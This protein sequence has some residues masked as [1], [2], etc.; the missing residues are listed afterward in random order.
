VWRHPSNQVKLG[1]SVF[2]AGASWNPVSALTDGR[3]AYDVH[4]AS[5]ASGARPL[6]GPEAFS[7]C[8]RKSS[9]GG[10][11]VMCL[12]VTMF[13]KV[14]VLV[15]LAQ[16]N[17]FR[18]RLGS[19]L[20]QSGRFPTILLWQH[21]TQPGFEFSIQRPAIA[22][23]ME[24]LPCLFRHEQLHEAVQKP[25][26]GRHVQKELL[27]QQLWVILRKDLDRFG[28]GG[29]DLWALTEEADGFVVVDLEYFVGVEAI[30]GR[31]RDGSRRDIKRLKSKFHQGDAPRDEFGE[32]AE[33]VLN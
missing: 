22:H 14:L 31:D 5:D 32:R 9:L 16:S 25:H 24:L 27:L 4:D 19:S 12:P 6:A 29:L 30:V 21:L 20:V 11:A 26:N 18:L 3:D 33:S 10:S 2:T 15:F 17:S 7:S 13:M 28:R 23:G 8:L 1:A